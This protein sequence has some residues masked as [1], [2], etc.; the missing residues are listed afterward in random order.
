MSAFL[1]Y[2]YSVNLTEA[3]ILIIDKEVDAN[4]VALRKIVKKF[5]VKEK[6]FLSLLHSG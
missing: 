1:A 5:I 4:R 6:S 2:S 3:E